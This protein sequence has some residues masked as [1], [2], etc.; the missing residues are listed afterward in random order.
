MAQM[1]A[2]TVIRKPEQESPCRN[3]GFL[4]GL[5]K[6]Y[7]KEQDY[8]MVGCSDLRGNFKTISNELERIAK[9]Q[10]IDV[11][12]IPA[13]KQLSRDPVEMVST[14]RMLEPYMVHLEFVT[15]PH[16]VTEMEIAAEEAY[17]DLKGCKTPW[18]TVL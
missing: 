5:L 6:D 13:R 4:E 3:Y 9:E 15:P 11:I 1:R 8:E 12:V 2:W 10:D 16:I 7:C 14:I 17:K 18:G